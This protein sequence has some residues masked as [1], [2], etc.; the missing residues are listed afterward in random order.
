MS[1]YT[2][3]GGTNGQKFSTDASGNG[4]TTR[5]LAYRLEGTDY[6]NILAVIGDP[7]IP[8]QG[9][10]HPDNALLKATGVK[11]FNIEAGGAVCE[12]EV[13]YSMDSSYG[14]GST[15]SDAAPWELPPSTFDFSVDIVTEVMN[16]DVRGIPVVSTSS[17][18]LNTTHEVEYP[19][20]NIAYSLKDF[21][22]NWIWQYRNTINA[23]TLHIM[24]HYFYAGQWK[25]ISLSA[26]NKKTY[27]NNGKIKWDYWDVSAKLMAD[28]V[29]CVGNYIMPEFSRDKKKIEYKTKTFERKDKVVRA[30]MREVPNLSIYQN[31]W[32]PIY[33][34]T[35]YNERAHFGTYDEMVKLA[36][37]NGKSKE[38]VTRITDPIWMDEN[39]YVSEI[40]P[41]TGYMKPY[42]L[43]FKDAVATNWE[44]LSFPDL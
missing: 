22:P 36:E 20:V 7:N 18:R 25:I 6:N 2:F 38:H 43:L 41:E 14:S 24:G 11:N 34:F 32:V 30:W 17:T 19:V 21:N 5:I 29:F 26:S 10:S 44:P 39:G 1:N 37:K 27:D 3:L 12:V 35:P 4:T 42:Y 9:T 33:S 40:D 15:D 31:G 28:P 23:K 13:E 16:Q 8:A